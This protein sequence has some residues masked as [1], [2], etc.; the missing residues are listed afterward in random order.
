MNKIAQLETQVFAM[1]KKIH[2]LESEKRE[3]ED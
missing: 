1:Q 2:E 3:D